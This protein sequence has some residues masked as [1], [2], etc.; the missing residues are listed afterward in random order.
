[1]NSDIFA[2]NG[3]IQNQRF[4]LTEELVD[5]TTI[6]VTVESTGGST[7]AWTQAKDISAVDKDSKVWY[8]QENDL[9]LFELYFG[10]GVISAEPL[11]GDTI[12]ISY[13]VTNPVHTENASIFTMTDAIGGNSNVTITTTHNSSGGK[14]KEGVESIRFVKQ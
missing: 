8:V 5:T 9:G 4:P 2:Y 7:S 12:T 3:Q 6:T 14:D 1:M 11:D 13:L 10:D